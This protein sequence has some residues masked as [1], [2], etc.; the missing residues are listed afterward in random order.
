MMS[1]IWSNCYRAFTWPDIKT[2]IETYKIGVK[3]PMGICVGICL[4][5]IGTVPHNC[6]Q[7]I[8]YQSQSVPSHVG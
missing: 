5:V 8:F 3:K 1:C 2:E 7:A 4:Y 6:V